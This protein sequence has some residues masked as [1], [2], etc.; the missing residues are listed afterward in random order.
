MLTKT[1]KPDFKKIT[2]LPGAL[3]FAG[4]MMISYVPSTV[5]ANSD[6]GEE[7]QSCA[8]PCATSGTTCA[9]SGVCKINW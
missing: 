5:L 2:G 1:L 7:D 9:S 3:L 8:A 4:S 6:P